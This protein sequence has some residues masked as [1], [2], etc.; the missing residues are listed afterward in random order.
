[1][2]ELRIAY[3]A[4]TTLGEADVRSHHEHLDEAAEAFARCSAPFKQLLWVEDGEPDWLDPDEERRLAEVCDRH[5]L[6]GRPPAEPS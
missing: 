5:G 2:Y 6:A 1:M 3:E 4:D